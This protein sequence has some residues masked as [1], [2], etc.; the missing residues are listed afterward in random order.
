MKTFIT[1]LFLVF[2]FFTCSYG[3]T[4][5]AAIR[6]RVDSLI[7]VWN[8]WGRA[9]DYYRVAEGAGIALTQ[10]EKSIGKQTAPYAAVLHMQG[11]SFRALGQYLE[12]EK[13]F[14]EAI[15]IREQ[16]FGKRHADYAASINSL[17]T[18]YLDIGHFDKAEPLFREALAIAEEIY[19]KENL[20]YRS[21]LNN[22]GILYYY[23]SQYEKAE[24]VFLEVRRLSEILMGKESAGYAGSVENLANLYTDLGQYAKAEPLYL[25]ALAIKE[26]IAGKESAS[27]A[28]TLSNLTTLYTANGDYSKAEQAVRTT[29]QIREKTLGPEHPDY[30]VSLS[31]LSGIYR[32]MSKYEDAVLLLLQCKTIYEKTTGK[33]SPDYA[34]VINDLAITYYYL[35]DYETAE[36]YYLESTAIRER[37]LGKEHADYAWSI[38]NLGVLYL[39]M[40]NHAKAEQLQIEALAIR[41]KALG[42]EHP[43]Y[44]ANLNNLAAVYSQT[45]K[46]EQAESLYLE[47]MKINEKIVGKAHEDYLR[48]AVNLSGL[49]LSQKKYPQAESLLLEV[50][51]IFET[52]MENREHLY[53]MN[54]L[55]SLGNLYRTTGRYSQAEPLLAAAGTLRN[56]VLGAAHLSV[57]LSATDMATLYWQTGRPELAAL[58]LQQAA[59]IRK[60]YLARAA[61][62][63]S[64]SETLAFTRTFE[65]FLHQFYSF[66]FVSADRQSGIINECYDHAL[67]YKSFLQNASMQIR[68]VAGVHPQLSG[69][70]NQHRAAVRVLEKEYAKPRTEQLQ[71]DSLAGI[72]NK[73]EKE[74]ARNV[75]GL[76]AVFGQYGWQDVRSA[77]QPGEAALEFIHFN[78]YHPEPTDSVLYAA[79]LLKPGMENPAFIP[80]FEE[81]NLRTLLPAAGEKMNSDQVNQLYSAHAA[82]GEN[83]LYQLLWGPLEAH[84]GGTT[85]VYYAPSGLLHR[86]NLPALPASGRIVLSDRYDMVALGSTRQLVSEKGRDI[87]NRAASAI[88]YG[89]IQFDMDST[90]YPVQPAGKNDALRGLFFGQGDSLLRVSAW[91]FLKWSEKEIDAVGSLLK[92]AGC[93]S[94]IRKGWQSTEESFK[95]I[96]QTA[97]SPNILHIS[98]HGFFFPDPSIIRS[99]QSEELTFRMSGHPMIRS[100]LIMAG[101]NYAWKTGRPLGNREDGILTAYEISQMDLSNTDLVLLSACETGLG[102]IEG[103]EEVY[104]LQRAFR[105]AGANTLVMSLWQVPDYQTQELMTLFY[106]KL[107]QEKL[108]ARQALHAAQGEMR[109]RWY[110]PYYWAGFVVVE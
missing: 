80:L 65:Q 19:G 74:L 101:A 24:P 31:I 78:Y 13:A 43:A 38:N 25:E 21:S 85:T 44:T 107:L 52:Q 41:E 106:Q 54:A 70:L 42:K 84:L 5:T 49:Y 63:L 17:G 20:P 4:D 88:L 28:F 45:G 16:L 50:K 75:A 40:G 91:K 32:G 90:A 10:V 109:R 57:A 51:L 86:L 27:Y 12:S 33:D 67:F 97:S 22:L 26:K 60:N 98:T 102:H 69:L 8:E 100:G 96:G 103:N 37:L 83:D 79:L 15:A 58:N 59:A 29:L 18:V 73:L 110:E 9:G 108:P 61:R 34:G 104:G 6:V 68:R 105:I 7:K 2:I 71:I 87:P 36:I 3:Q 77:L 66:A 76:D 82:T 47:A 14:K 23:S 56:Q 39:T 48:N 62:H 72:A 11:I 94:E 1:T 35:G 55:A 46:E 30:A 93:P 95:Q 99:S 92:A 64:E 81:K 53:Y 89:G